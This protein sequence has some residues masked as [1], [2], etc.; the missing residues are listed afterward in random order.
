MQSYY[1]FFAGMMA[2]WTPSLLVLALMLRRAFLSSAAA[3]RD[4]YQN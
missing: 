4:E 1:W 3:G 2:A